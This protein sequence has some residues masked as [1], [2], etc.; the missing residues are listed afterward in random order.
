MDASALV[1]LSD[2]ASDSGYRVVR[3]ASFR[4]A[5]KIATRLHDMVVPLTD[6]AYA[7]QLR[8]GDKFAGV[9]TSEALADLVPEGLGLAIAKDPAEAHA[10]L[11]A[12]LCAIPG[13][14]WTSFPTEIGPG[15]DI[16]PSAVIPPRDVRIGAGSRIGHGVVIHPRSVIGEKVG[17]HEHCVVGSAAYEVVRLGGQQVLRPQAGG[18]K[19]G[20]GVELLP[21]VS[22]S[23]T[24]FGG[25]TELGEAVVV[26]HKT[27]VSH[28][29]EIGEETRIGGLSWIG[30]RVRIGSH[31]IIGPQVTIANGL[32]LGDRCRVSL[33]S[34]V[35]RD[36]DDGQRV[37]GNFAI[38]HDRFI[39]RLR[40][41]R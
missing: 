16:A 15:C 1:T 40:N 29:V 26:D 41:S 11:H 35:T 8:E 30:G 9:I 19:L 22:V 20:D 18:V 27:V 23:R 24:A 2:F 33:G 38:P 14:L 13:H 21:G 32:V 31:A 34:V 6:A 3:D 25:F 17:V 39:E 4:F 36:V 5:A 10:A 12:R 7:G 28:D 37:T